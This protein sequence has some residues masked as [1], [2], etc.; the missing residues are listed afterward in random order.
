MH[1]L[2]TNLTPHDDVAKAR[3]L[4][5]ERALLFRPGEYKFHV[6]SGKGSYLVTIT[7]SKVCFTWNGELQEV[8]LYRGMSVPILPISM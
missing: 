3:A 8:P 7:D 4:F 2:L 6:C 5:A 1:A